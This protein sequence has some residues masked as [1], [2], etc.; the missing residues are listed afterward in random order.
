MAA[1]APAPYI[2]YV[3]SGTPTCAT[4]IRLAQQ[5]GPQKITIMDVSRNRPPWLKGVPTLINTQ[6]Q[7]PPLQG[8]AVQQWLQKNLVEDHKQPQAAGGGSRVTGFSYVGATQTNTANIYA[9][10]NKVTE[11]DIEQYLQ[12][13]NAPPKA[14]PKTAVVGIS[15]A[16]GRPLTL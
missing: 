3:L 15:P 11:S 2:L 5:Y 6:T 4:A 16:D 10:K 1:A 13:R 12:Y 14:P 7:L 9:N 8:E